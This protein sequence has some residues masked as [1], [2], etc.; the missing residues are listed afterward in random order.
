MNNKLILF[1]SIVTILILSFSA[2]NCIIVKTKSG[3]INGITVTLNDK[4]INKFLG[5]PYAEPP[6]G[7]Y[8]FGKTRAIHPWNN[9]YDAT[10]FKN[11]CFQ[12]SSMYKMSEDCLFLNIFSEERKSSDNKLRP[13]MFWIHGGG[14]TSGD[15][16]SAHWF[17]GTVL[18]SEG[19]V[20]VS[21]AIENINFENFQ[22]SQNVIYFLFESFMKKMSK[23]DSIR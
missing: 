11:S 9:T 12:N 5:V 6:I 21:I 2:I 15:G 20:I 1:N 14:L 19:V 18:S 13:V 16:Y 23:L 7:S 3:P 10:N 4:V 17:D 22:F 8:R